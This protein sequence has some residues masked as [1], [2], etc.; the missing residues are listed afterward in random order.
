MVAL[1]AVIN[2]VA[3]GAALVITALGHA[4]LV[5]RGTV[6][7]PSAQNGTAGSQDHLRP[8]VPPAAPAS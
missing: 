3:S 2:A 4:R 6:A 1:V 8:A 7:L 5:Q